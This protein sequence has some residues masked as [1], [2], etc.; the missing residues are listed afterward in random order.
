MFGTQITAFALP[1]V[2]ARE[3]NVSPFQMGL[4]G[5]AQF[6]P[7]LL[8]GLLAGVWVD[9]LRRRPVLI[10][11]DLCRA[12]LLATIPLAAL[13]GRLTLPQLY[14]VALLAG[15]CAI[16]FEIAYQSF[17]PSLLSRDDLMEGNS[18]LETSR[19]VAQI[20]GPGLGGLLVELLRAP[21][22]LAFDALS[23]LISALCMWRVRTPEPERLPAVRRAIRAELA[24][25]LRFAAGEPRLRS[26]AG[27]VAT[28]NLAM[29][30][31]FAVYV[32]YL[33]ERL[34]VRPNALGLLFALGS[35][36]SIFGATLAP[37]LG[38]RF[39][40]GPV[41]L[42]AALVSG[43]GVSCLALSTLL[44]RGPALTLV[45]VGQVLPAFCAPVFAV[46]QMSL[47][48]VV[49]P[50]HLRGR[51]NAAIR[52]VTAGLNPAGP[53]I[54]GAVG[55]AFG[56]PAALTLSAALMLSASLWIVVSPLPRTKSLG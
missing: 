39:G 35:A 45:V 26:I 36:G 37:R 52:F 25:G 12:G 18:R 34:E 50:N 23:F 42:T 4:L 49:I 56:L 10:T 3:F 9:R 2:A 16:F 33:V 14:V 47:R 29:G 43:V 46:N 28:L 20:G 8:L 30:V 48:Q 21:F 15:G 17:L 32:L 31:M 19:S 1:L 6:L 22:L 40:I 51:V 44:P 38:R 24:E 13:A 5:A 41:L 54:G 55:A 53:L 27:C 7:H 11:A